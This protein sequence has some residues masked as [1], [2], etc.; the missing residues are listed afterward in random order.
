MQEIECKGVFSITRHRKIK[1]KKNPN[2]TSS[3]KQWL[4]QADNTNAQALV[5]CPVKK[6]TQPRLVSMPLVPAAPQA[7]KMEAKPV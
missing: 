6:Q 1:N 5:W 4:E 7:R 2:K 3:H